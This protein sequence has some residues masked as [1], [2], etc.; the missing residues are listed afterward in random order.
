MGA[1]L[2]RESEQ[3][4]ASLVKVYEEFD[5]DGGGD[6]GEHELLLLGQTRR[7]LGQKGGEWT[8][9]MNDKLMRKIGTDGFG[10]IPS[11][12]FAK[13]F[14]AA[15]PNDTDEFEKIIEQFIACAHACR[16]SKTTKSS[17]SPAN[18]SQP[19]AVVN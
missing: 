11:K 14:D 8:K 19:A 4:Q 9:E 13:H 1:S 3:R 18:K 15:L 2:V 7:K 5:L 6:V 17:I 12:C 16:S 10:N